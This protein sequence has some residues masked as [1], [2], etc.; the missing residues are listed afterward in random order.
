MTDLLDLTKIDT[1][2]VEL[3]QGEVNLIDLLEEVA[4][5]FALGA[6]TKG[7]ELVCHPAAD[8]PDS[9]L[10]DRACLRQVLSNLVGNAVKF[11]DHGEVV[12]Q[13][14]RVDGEN[15]K[16]ALRFI[17]RD[18]GIGIDQ[19]EQSKVFDRFF[20]AAGG[21]GQRLAGSGLG[22]SIAHRLAQLLAGRI[23]FNSEL[24]RGSTFFFEL[25][26]GLGG[27]ERSRPQSPRCW[28]AGC[29]L[30]IVDSNKSS[31]RALLST[32][33]SWDLSATA[34]PEIPAIASA[35]GGAAGGMRVALIGLSANTRAAELAAIAQLRT[36]FPASELRIILLSPAPIPAAGAIVDLAISAVVA[37][38]VRRTLLLREL[39]RALDLE[40][41]AAGGEKGAVPRT[42]EAP[43]GQHILLAEDNREN[44]ILGSLYLQKGGY[45]V[46][47][48]ENGAIALQKMK[49]G[50][51]DLILMDLDMPVLDGFEAADRIR[52]WEAEVGG[53][54]IPIVA[55][56]AHAIKEFR[57]RCFS[58]GMD[59]Y[60][61]KPI[62][63]STLLRKVSKALRR[64]LDG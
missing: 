32:L 50:A 25:P 38:P 20:Q 5:Q 51:Y 21:S 61:A 24:R 18:T 60:L 28:P 30:L 41:Q 47:L 57:D 43:S 49:T 59:D 64:P 16:A 1:Q 27:E 62:D 2:Q 26:Y 9:V 37:K 55:L 6:Q 56:T 45:A 12:L 58:C 7:L 36:R 31:R 13:A 22:L 19:K 3:D 4:G 63:R 23:W 14:M 39:T 10:S 44:Q 40:M 46:D 52:A 33:Q 42:E 8:M 48:A 53:E 34:L 35:L 54:R 15:G 11:T 17:V 29:S